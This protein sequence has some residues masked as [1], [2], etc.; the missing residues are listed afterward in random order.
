MTH[1]LQQIWEQATEDC[2]TMGIESLE[3]DERLLYGIKMRRFHKDGSI[4]IYDT[5]RGGE[6]YRILKGV[7]LDI[8]RR[9]G[10]VKACCS[11]A[12]NRLEEKIDRAQKNYD[13]SINSRC[14]TMKQQRMR[15]DT[16]EALLKTSEKIIK[17]KLT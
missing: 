9:N 7:E 11:I 12:S 6:H 2:Y 5:Y 1:G 14:Y 4:T 16:L 3:F 15:L 17:H 10:W 13:D 8:F